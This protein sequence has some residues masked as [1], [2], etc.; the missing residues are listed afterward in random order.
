MVY[1]MMDTLQK[2]TVEVQVFLLVHA[3]TK[4]TQGYKI[5]NSSSLVKYVYFGKSK[6]HFQIYLGFVV[7]QFI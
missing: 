2:N 7:P 1:K 4:S 6:M 3:C 5:S